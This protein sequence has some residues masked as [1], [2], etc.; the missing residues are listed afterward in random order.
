MRGWKGRVRRLTAGVGALAAA[1]ALTIWG[2]SPAL[3]G[4]PTSVLVVSPESEETA[5]LYYADK[6]YATLER[7]LGP[8][9]E[10][11]RERP[12]EAVSAS[13]R[14]INVTWLV[15]DVTPWRVD[16]VFLGEM[17]QDV[18]IHTASRFHES[19]NGLW[20]R[21][22]DA[23]NVHKFLYE[24][25]VM[26]KTTGS[27]ASSGIYPAPWETERAATGADQGAATTA[28][29][30]RAAAATGGGTDWWWAIPGLVAGAAAALVLRPYVTGWL[31]R[32]KDDPGPRQELLDV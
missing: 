6:G 16:R 23:S 31:S 11:T 17:G 8:V 20:H 2:A 4:G 7:L 30:P 27:P 24:L 21:A 25:G 19:P 32:R 28:P 1:L 15:H 9:G 14:M 13:A 18:W 29:E 12:L 26:G 10:G 3:A 22:K 5:S